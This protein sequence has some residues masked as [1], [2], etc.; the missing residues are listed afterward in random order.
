MYHFIKDEQF[1]QARNHYNVRG[2]NE[3]HKRKHSS[4]KRE[5]HFTQ[6]TL[7]YCLVYLI[8]NFIDC[9][10]LIANIFSLDVYGAY[11]YFSVIA[12]C[13]LFISHGVHFFICYYFNS[14]FR[15]EAKKMFSRV[16]NWF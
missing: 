8:G 16:S 10:S 4:E 3:T 15:K 7:V 11:W 1:N 2:T 14:V 12:N 5:F 6:L 13:F 9:F